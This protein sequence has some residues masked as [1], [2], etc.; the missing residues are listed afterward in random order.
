[1]IEYSI[2]NSIMNN[3]EWGNRAYDLSVCCPICKFDYSSI[4]NIREVSGEDS[5]K[6]SWE[7]RG[8]LTILHFEGECGHEWELCFG[9][10]KGKTIMFCRHEFM[11]EE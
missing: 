7:G 11:K 9:F 10:H 4:T 1:M 3:N 8:E 6:A 2:T 5:Y